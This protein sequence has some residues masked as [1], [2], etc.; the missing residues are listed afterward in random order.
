[1]AVGCTIMNG[2]EVVLKVLE[3]VAYLSFIAGG[4]TGLL[5]IW[6]LLIA[7]FDKQFRKLA[8]RVPKDSSLNGYQWFRKLKGGRW[9]RYWVSPDWNHAG[10]WV[11]NDVRKDGI[12]FGCRGTPKVEEY[13]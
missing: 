13:P 1:M 8:Q 6:W 10:N 5:V 12:P 9:E 7:V 2:S 11:Q 4:I 3:A